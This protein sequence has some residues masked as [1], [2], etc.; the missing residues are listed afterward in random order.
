M[1]QQMKTIL[2]LFFSVSI[3]MTSLAQAQSLDRHVPPPHLYAS[4]ACLLRSIQRAQTVD[5]RNLAGLTRPFSDWSERTRAQ[6]LANA[7]ITRFYQRTAEAILSRSSMQRSNQ[8]RNENIWP[9]LSAY[10]SNH[11]GAYA[12]R[13]YELTQSHESDRDLMTRLARLL[14]PHFELAAVDAAT[15]SIRQE[16]ISRLLQGNIESYKAFHWQF[17]AA[18]ECSRAEVSSLLMNWAREKSGQGASASSVSSAFTS[19]SL[20]ALS[21][22]WGTT[23]PDSEAGL[24]SGV[25]I[26]GILVHFEQQD[27][28]QPIIFEGFGARVFGL[29]LSS[30]AHLQQGRFAHLPSYSIWHQA[31]QTDSAGSF[32]ELGSRTAYMKYILARFATE[33]L[34][35]TDTTLAELREIEIAALARWHHFSRN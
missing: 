2:P 23:V 33:M 19:N 16:I 34:G 3:L 22:A 29:M 11:V 26:A 15:L 20:V 6:L 32:A 24:Q 18:H 21:S 13:L 12:A 28:L 17:R 9:I 14:I 10:V 35:D 7:Q 27:L 5:E 31:I 1:V 30:D 8:R 25:Q 4:N